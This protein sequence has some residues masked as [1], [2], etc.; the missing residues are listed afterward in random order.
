MQR[1]PR[2]D[3]KPEL[4]LR[5]ELHRLG[6]RYLLDRSVLP[7]SRRRHD[8]VFSRQRVVVEVYGC[9]W[10]GCPKHATRPK[11]N[12]G[13]WAEKL[14]ANVARDVDTERRLAEAGWLLLV[15]WEHENPTEAA[16]RVLKAVRGR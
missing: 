4:Q 8:I 3:T 9:F 10:H 1:Q 6:L 12:S 15:V 13:W 16:Q 14:G 2:R 11:A 5:R 7:K